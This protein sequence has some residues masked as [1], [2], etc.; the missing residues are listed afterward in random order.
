MGKTIDLYYQINTDLVNNLNMRNKNYYILENLKEIKNNNSI[1]DQ[2]K[3]I[4]GNIPLFNKVENI[5]NIYNKIKKDDLQN[6]LP[7]IPVIEKIGDIKENHEDKILDKKINKDD[8][9]LNVK[10]FE[11]NNNKIININKFS[12]E[13]N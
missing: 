5:V 8:D 11:D 12:S 7:I 3:I 1:I 9:N 2:L 13:K 6:E 10:N 4:N